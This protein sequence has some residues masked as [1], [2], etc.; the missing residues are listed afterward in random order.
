MNIVRVEAE[1]IRVGFHG[2]R[3]SYWRPN[4]EGIFQ[5]GWSWIDICELSKLVDEVKRE[6]P[7]EKGYWTT[8]VVTLIRKDSLGEDVFEEVGRLEGYLKT[9]R[10]QKRWHEVSFKTSNYSDGDTLYLRP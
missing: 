1:S 3:E 9:L 8:P 2:S 7:E 10:H 4:W 6:V 5:S